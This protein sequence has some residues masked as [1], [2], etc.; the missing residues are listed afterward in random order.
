M[1]P[2]KVCHCSIDAPQMFQENQGIPGMADRAARH[3]SLEETLN[4]PA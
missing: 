4:Y 3:E 2:D 1:L